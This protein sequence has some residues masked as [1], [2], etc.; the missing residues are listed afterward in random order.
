MF[1]VFRVQGTC[2]V[3]GNVVLFRWGQQHSSNPLAGFEGPLRGTGEREG[4][5]EGR[6]GTVRVGEKHPQINFWFRPW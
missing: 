1:G 3:A 2:L 4:K 6:K 5:M